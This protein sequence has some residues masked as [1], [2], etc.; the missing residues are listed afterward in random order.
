M[1]SNSTWM[2]WTPAR[3]ASTAAPP[4]GHEATQHVL[5]IAEVANAHEGRASDALQTVQAAATA[6]CGAVKFQ[7][8]YAD[9]MLAPGHSLIPMFAGWEWGPAVWRELIETARAANLKVFVDVFGV[10]AYQSLTDLPPVDGLK[11]HAADIYNLPLLELLKD[12]TCPILIGTGACSDLDIYYAISRLGHP[13]RLVLMHGYQAFPTPLEDTALRRIPHLLETFGTAVGLSEHLDADNS[14]AKVAPLM[15]IPLGVCCIEKHLTLNRAARGIDHASA[16]NPDE[17]RELAQWVRQAE[18]AQGQVELP[19]SASEAG[20]RRRFKKSLITTVPLA[21]G[22]TITPNHIAYRIVENPLRYSLHQSDVVGQTARHDLCSGTLLSAQD[23]NL[24]VGLC[25]IARL[26]SQ[27]LPGKALVD[28]QGKPA[29]VHLIERAK[30][31]EIVACPVLC[32][33]THP[34]D[35]PLIHLARDHGLD[36]YAGSPEQP[37]ERLI[38]CAEMYGWQ[39]VIRATGD[40]IFLD[41]DLLTQAVALGTEQNLD[42]VSMRSVPVGTHCEVFSTFALRTIQQYA[43]APYTTEYLTWFIADNPN[44]RAMDLPVPKELQRSYRLTLD[45]PED[46]ANIRDVVTRLAAVPQPYTLRD[47]I[48]AVESDPD[49]QRRC[50]AVPGVSTPPA[51]VRFKF[52]AGAIGVMF[53]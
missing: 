22:E 5:L 11:I 27:R 43:D 50:T 7:K 10:R 48:G 1:F 8:Y 12:T 38:A 31:S 30:L 4:V 47:V 18:V 2:P 9:E 34:Q 28:I 49:L 44:F 46:L 37:L 45:T 14:F 35:A 33:S 41:P 42:Y 23:L 3:H 20:Y 39:Y 40:N 51:R 21:P 26:K 6:G 36:T 17:M 13:E 16:L 32:T 52:N 15:A 25:L 53:P 24:K 29:L 19:P